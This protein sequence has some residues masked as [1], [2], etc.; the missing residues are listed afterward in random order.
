MTTFAELGLKEEIIH[1]VEDL[2]FT[3]PMPIQEA[4][5]PLLLEGNRDVTGL[6]QTGTGK[7]AAFGLPIL[8]HIDPKNRATQALILSPTRELALQIQRELEKYSRHIKGI[9]TTAVYGGTSIGQQISE[10]KRGAHIIVA[11]PGRLLDLLKRRA[12]DLQGLNTLVLDEADEM[13]NFGFQDELN[14]IL[15]HTPKDKRTLLFSATMS[16]EVRKIAARYMNDPE[17]IVAGERNAGAAKVKHLYYMVQAKDRYL[18]LKRIVDYNPDIYGII[19][20]RTRQETQDIA[21]KLVRD[22]Y[23]VESLHGDLSQAQREQ[24]MNKFRIKNLQLIVATDVAARGLD[25]KNLTHI[26]NYNLPEDVENYTHRSG[27]TGRAGEEGVSVA[28]LHSREKQ[29]LRRIEEVSGIKFKKEMVPDGIAICQRQLFA[30]ID[31]ME[32]VDVDH[33][34]IHDFLPQ[35]YKKLQFLT[36]EEIIQRFVSLEFNM[37]LDY[38]RKA[39]DLNAPEKSEP[40]KRKRD[41][42]APFTRFMITAGREQGISPKDLIG[43]IN[44]NNK[45][46]RIDV[47]QIDIMKKVSFFD[48]DKKAENIIVSS[49]NGKT[50][51]GKKV[52]VSKAHDSYGSKKKRG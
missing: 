51:K 43:F 52:E 7:T 3:E 23:N 20:C 40:K 16:K 48:V 21:E 45:G 26:I 10:V 6:A 9:T 5:I 35:V 29:K 24:V 8:H 38:Y 28:I 31:R 39:P 44:R 15:E 14:E 30:M 1:A 36:K 50:L 46:R 37:F 34:Q 17:E 12:V 19:F 32:Q 13:L 42:H 47:G 41:P 33:E 27:R 4:V 18:A 25:V 22:N 49:L 2:G 11:T